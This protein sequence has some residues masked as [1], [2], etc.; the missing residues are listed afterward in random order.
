MTHQVFRATAVFLVALGF[1]LQS[2]PEVESK[3]SIGG[4][5]GSRQKPAGWGSRY[6]G[7]SSSK[8]F[9]GNSVAFGAGA[10]IGYKAA[11]M[12]KKVRL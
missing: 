10:F 1:I 8:S 2:I 11:K 4:G 9:I 12:A 6:T 3:G 7:K 5:S